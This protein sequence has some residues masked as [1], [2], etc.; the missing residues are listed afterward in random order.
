MPTLLEQ[1]ITE[2]D[3]QKLQELRNL[4]EEIIETI[5]IILDKEAIKKIK[6]AEQDI[7]QGRTKTWNQFKKTKTLILTSLI[8]SCN[9][10]HQIFII[11]NQTDINQ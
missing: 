8:Q 7:K 3:K 11:Y 2:K 4:L 1:I 5:D 6:E 10:S 9:T